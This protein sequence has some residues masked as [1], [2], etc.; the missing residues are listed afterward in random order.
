MNLGHKG[1][2]GVS[3]G[4]GQSQ[5]LIPKSCISSP[6]LAFS[7]FTSHFHDDEKGFDDPYDARYAAGSE[8]G[9][10]DPTVCCMPAAG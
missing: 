6:P 4:Q 1:V 9:G 3:S 7:T 8:S 2:V 10:R 5:L